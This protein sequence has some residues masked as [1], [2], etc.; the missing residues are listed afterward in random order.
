[1]NE[2]T[3]Y[4]KENFSE[5]KSLVNISVS[6]NVFIVH[7]KGS[8]LHSGARDFI[9]KLIEDK[10]VESFSD[11]NPNPQLE[12]LK[13]GVELFHNGSY[14]LII[15]IGGGSVL[16]MAKLISMFAHQHDDIIE[17]AKGECA[18][19]SKNTPV[20]A[21]PT[22]AGA[23]AEATAFSVLYIDKTKYSVAHQLMRP[24]YVYLS[25]D[26][27]MSASKYQTACSG[28]DAFCQAVESVWSI[29]ATEESIA[30]ASE[31]IGLAW[32]YLPQSVNKNDANAKVMMQEAAYLAGKAI[33]I[34]KTTAPHAISYA[35]TSYYGIPHGHAVALSV[36]FFLEYN[37]KLTAEGC[38]D[39]K[40]VQAVKERIEIILSLLGLN[41]FEAKDTL[42]EF[43]KMLGISIY[44]PELIEGFSKTI[45][46]ENINIERLNNNPRKVSRETIEDFLK[47]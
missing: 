39:K 8:Y 18:L 5:L 19:E 17:L 4:R 22:T 7:G 9:T 35:F 47:Q 34:T 43:F 10:H 31:A 24:Q 30:Y 33:N 11:F 2:Q 20:L 25:A 44:I 15:A 37:Y 26:F 6:G 28:L 38:N 27:S 36:P 46:K 16:D 42:S 29:N 41:V 23:G 40:G 3:V 12:D 32:K 21:I 13:K 14:E 45:I 1:M